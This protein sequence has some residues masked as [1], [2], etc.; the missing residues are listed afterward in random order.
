MAV[1]SEAGD[2][3]VM[4]GCRVGTEAST[5]DVGLYGRFYNGTMSSWHEDDRTKIIGEG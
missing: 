5:F 2:E 4:D 3:F 1:A